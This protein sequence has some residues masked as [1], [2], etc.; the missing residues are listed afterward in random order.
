MFVAILMMCSVV[1]LSA[2]ENCGDKILENLKAKYSKEC[3]GLNFEAV[4]VKVDRLMH[5]VVG[6]D[7]TSS[8]KVE[9]KAFAKFLYNAEYKSLKE[10]DLKYTALLK[11]MS[12]AAYGD[13][14]AWVYEQYTSSTISALCE[15]AT[16]IDLGLVSVTTSYDCTNWWSET[17]CNLNRA[18][19]I[20]VQEGILDQE[21]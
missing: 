6:R 4:L 17:S 20:L 2:K 18:K 3:T 16:E 19:Y 1:S 12:Y 9:V 8:E 10:V 7:I 11:A 5:N 13:C 15:P 21:D 14:P